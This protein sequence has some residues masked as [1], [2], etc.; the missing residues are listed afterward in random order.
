VN[1][2][3]TRQLLSYLIDKHKIVTIA[4]L[5]KLCYL[6]DLLSYQESKQQISKFNYV[7]WYTG[8]YDKSVTDYLFELVKDG[9][10]KVEIDYAL[11]G[12]EY[13]RYS[14]SNKNYKKDKLTQADIN[15]I[16]AVLYSLRDYGSKALVEVTYKT[17]PMRALDASLENSRNIGKKLELSTK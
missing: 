17:K 13:T 1:D 5:M 11:D 12:S 8:P 6:S 15:N 2:E 3:K 7:H 10:V 14:I 4:S 9:T 16:E